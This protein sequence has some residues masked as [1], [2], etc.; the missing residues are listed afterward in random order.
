MQQKFSA[1]LHCHTD[2]ALLSSPFGVIHTVI[3]AEGMVLCSL[4]V[5]VVGFIV[6]HLL[7]NVLSTGSAIPFQA[8]TA[9]KSE[10]FLLGSH[11]QQC[12]SKGT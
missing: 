10:R 4:M 3:T 7:A 5:D 8:F 12:S 11:L 9:S 2:V 6:D 1:T